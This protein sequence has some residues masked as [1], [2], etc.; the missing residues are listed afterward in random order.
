MKIQ[1]K[2]ILNQKLCLICVSIAV[3]SLFSGCAP[4]KKKFT[5]KKKEGDQQQKFVPVLEPIDYEVVQYSPQERYHQAYSLW[6]VW[7]KD[8][9]LSMEKKVNSK[10]Q[11]YLL[12]KIVVQLE[13]MKKWLSN[14]KKLKLE[15]VVLEYKDIRD[16]FQNA[17]NLGNIRSVKRQI[18]SNG[19]KIRLEFSFKSLDEASFVKM[20]TQQ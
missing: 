8:L 17:V 15:D 19:K 7:Q 13:E 9:L 20:E 10:N 12:D 2:K 1:N 18:E 3:M 14:D 4:L 6:A 16:K 5:R 11:K